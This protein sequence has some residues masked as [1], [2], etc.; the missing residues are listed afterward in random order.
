[1]HSW[2]R[3]FVPNYEGRFPNASHTQSEEEIIKN[4]KPNMPIPKSSFPSYNRTPKQ[5]GYLN[6]LHPNPRNEFRTC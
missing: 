3:K 6:T 4:R 1:M 5:H 2:Q